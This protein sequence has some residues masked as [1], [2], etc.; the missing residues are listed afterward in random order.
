MTS[1]ETKKTLR[2]QQAQDRPAAQRCRILFADQLNL[3]RGKYVPA[4]EARKGHA[5]FCVGAYAVTYDKQLVDAP[6]GGLLNGLPDMEIRFDPGALRKSWEAGTDIALGQLYAGGEPFA[7]CGRTALIRAIEAWRARGLEPMVGIELEAYIF[8]PDGQGGW[9]PYQTPGAF[10]YGTGPFADPAGLIDEI[11][12]AAE[13][14][15]IPVESINAEFDAPQ[16]ELTLRFADALKAADDAFLFRQMARELLFKR[17]YLL[18]FLPKPIP[19]ISGS[20]LHFNLSFRDTNGVNVFAADVASGNYSELMTGTIAGL[21]HHHRALAG[22]MAP[23]TNSYARLQPASLS[24]YWANWGVDHRSVTVRVSAEQGAAARIEHRL[25]DCAA[26]P[27]F[28]LA[29][30][31]RAALLG[32]EKGYTLPP[33]ETADG[34][35]NVSTQNHAPETLEDALDAL[36]ADTV[37]A[38]AISPEL[39]ANYVS[40]KRQEALTLKDKSEAER[41]AYYLHYI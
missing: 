10:V 28:A 29:S 12:A 9:Q 15:G 27:Y 13:A 7:L 25:A 6:G 16:W 37:L 23:L 5:R 3:A 36:A 26:S 32:V 8:E 21:L 30:L 17:S 20:G 22:I 18:S 40:I 4:I 41:I 34:L 11:W 1:H 39:V 38:G 2:A 24:G 33:A 31:L 19:G 35:E 14:C